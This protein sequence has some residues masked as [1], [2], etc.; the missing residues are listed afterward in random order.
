M[1]SAPP[2]PL[3]KKRKKIPPAV[4]AEII[5]GI[6]LVVGG[7]VW[8]PKLYHLYQQKKAEKEAAEIAA[9]QP[10]PAP[11]EPDAAEIMRTMGEK[12]KTMS[13]L[14]ATGKTAATLDMS[15]LAPNNPAAKSVTLTADT[16]IRISRPDLFRLE[17][18]LQAGGASVKGSAWDAGKGNYVALTPYPAKV[19]TREAALS[20]VSGASAT[21]GGKLISMFFDDKD[22]PA[23][24]TN[25]F[26]KTNGPA[27]NGE[28]CY[29]LVADDNG[30]QLELWVNKKNFLVQQAAVNLLGQL[31]DASYKA[32]TNSA[33]KAQM[34]RASKIH[35]SITE[36]Y[37]DIAVGTAMAA[38]DFEKPI[39]AAT[40]G[41]APEAP[42]AAPPMRRRAAPGGAQ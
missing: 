27:V 8:G 14:A 34:L 16:A 12:Y 24:A 10:P 3:K 36:T 39:V 13:S 20:Q 28:D 2:T 41:A 33:I 42:P 11:P 7:I 19:K 35:G 6:A 5:V 25:R 26:V 40:P 32:E 30:A 21:L 1:Q 38:A 9:T 37:S 31:D 18:N 23:T 17:W 4:L 22:N 15:E 29:I